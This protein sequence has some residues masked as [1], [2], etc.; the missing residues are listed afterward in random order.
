MEKIKQLTTQSPILAYY[1]PQAELVIEC[2]ASET[3]LGAALLQK[4]RPIAYASRS[5]TDT[6]TRYAQLE[7][8]CLAIVFS[9]ERFHQYTFGR[10]TIVH[11]DH[12]PLEM[13]VKKPLYKAPR[14]LQGMLLRMLQ[15][16]TEVVYHKGKEMY[17]ADT[18]SRSYLQH[19]GGT[20]NFG[21]VNAVKQLPISTERLAMLKAHTESDET[22]QTLKHVIQRGW[23]ET[24]DE[25]PTSIHAYFSMRDELAVHDGLVFRGERV[26][27]PDG[28]RKLT[29]ECL[30][31]SHLGVESVL[32]RARECIYWPNMASD[33]RQVV[34]NCEAYRTYERAQQ[35]ETLMQQETP[36]RQW[37][38]VGVDLFSWEGRDY[39]VL[40]DYTS[41]F[42]EVDRMTSTTTASVIKTMKAHFARNG[43]PSVIVSD[44]GPQYVSDEFQRFAAKWDIEHQTSAPGHQ[45]ANGRAEAAVKAAKLMFTKCKKSQTDPHLALLEIRN[46]PTQGVGSSPAQRLLNRR[47]RT[48][49]PTTTTLLAPRAEEYLRKDRVRISEQKEK[50]GKNYNRTAKDL[51][52]LEEG[53]IVRMKPFRPGQKAW[54]K[55]VVQRRLDERSYEVD[56]P[57]GTYR[58][59]RVH[60][61]RTHED[62]TNPQTQ[63]PATE[64]TPE[65]SEPADQ[66]PEMSDATV[67][68]PR[69]SVR[70]KKRSTRLADYITNV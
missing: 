24:R 23:P 55:A 57:A 15:Y 18:L 62:A 50:Q 3:G 20:D 28:M 54:E 19:Q 21:A 25:T 33:I 52:I 37:E 41:N 58:R 10:R 32:R 56:T 40:V 14:R 67:T 39:H 66:S 11:S 5:L 42:W 46:T 13:I 29:K 68:T 9:L 53:D 26:V 60:L 36:T 43:I 63:E 38:K 22:L 70:L 65:P 44:N 8:E 4:G 27:I 45:S 31:S 69:R 2:D 16:D 30:H 17:I 61:R 48:L 34:E 59:N 6:E 12:K 51:P 64:T 47:T 7:K 49:L 1:E 35:K